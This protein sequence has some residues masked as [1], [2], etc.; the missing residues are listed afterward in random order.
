MELGEKPSTEMSLGDKA[1]ITIVLYIF[2][3]WSE[4]QHCYRGSERKNRKGKGAE[5][6]AVPDGEASQVRGHKIYSMSLLW[7]NVKQA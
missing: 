7:K 2:K 3:E 4:A 5:V 6:E 1:W